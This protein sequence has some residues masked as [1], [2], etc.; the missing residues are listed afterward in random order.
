MKHCLIIIFTI[1]LFLYNGNSVYAKKNSLK[2]DIEKPSAAELT[3][4]EMSAGSFIVTSKGSEN[5]DDYK[6]NQIKFSGYDKPRKSSKETFFITNG[7]DRTMTGVVLY[8]DY[9]TSDGRQLDRQSVKLKCN[10]PAGQTR[11]AE[12]D[13]WDKQKAF[14]YEKSNDGKSGGTP[15]TVVFKPVSFYLSY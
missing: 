15:Y 11:M 13:S 14:Y 3:E 8:I 12:I 1:C 5:D 7:T 6:L 2:L 9:R 10:I 4:Q